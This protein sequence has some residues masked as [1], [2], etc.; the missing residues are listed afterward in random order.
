MKCLHMCR[1]TNETNN[2]FICNKTVF[3]NKITDMN[4]KEQLTFMFLTGDIY[5]LNRSALN[6]HVNSLIPN[7]CV[8]PQNT[9]KM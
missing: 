7:S 3:K 4:L 1:R 5:I 8:T 9:E 2:G 6:M